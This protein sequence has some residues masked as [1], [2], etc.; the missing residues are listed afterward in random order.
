[1]EVRFRFFEYISF[2]KIPLAL[3]HIFTILCF[4]S[5]RS[6]SAILLTIVQ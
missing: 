1:M 4:I 5:L 3:A 6:V 2:K